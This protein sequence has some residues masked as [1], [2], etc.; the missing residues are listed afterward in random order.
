MIEFIVFFCLIIGA[1]LL[2]YGCGILLPKVLSTASRMKAKN[3]Q[4][5]KHIRRTHSQRSTDRFGYYSGDAPFFD[6]L[7]ED[8]MDSLIG[9]W[10][11]SRAF[12]DHIN[13]DGVIVRI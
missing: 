3:D 2:A 7:A 10:E 11:T 6:N 1:T 8:V 9:Y 4:I 12:V 13:T 5:H